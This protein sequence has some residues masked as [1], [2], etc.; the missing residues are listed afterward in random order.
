MGA[1]L[2]ELIDLLDLEKIEE[3]IFR[4]RQ[5][6]E[7]R[8]RVFGGQVAGQALVA[9]T[10]T[11]EPERQVHSLHA[12]FLRPGDPSIPILY[13][14]D[15]IRDGRSFTTRRVVG[16]QHGKA[17][18]NLAAS[19]HTV[20]DG[21]DFSVDGP[22]APDPE[23]LPTFKERMAPYADQMGDW[24]HRPRPIDMRYVDAPLPGAEK[25]AV[26]QTSQRV[27]MRADG[28]LPDDDPTL[29]ACIVTYA[30]DM[31]LLDTTLLPHHVRWTENTIQMASLDHAMW[32][33]RPF[34]ADEWLL[35]VQDTPSTSSSRGL[36]R[37]LI[38]DR[39]GDVVV[40]VMQEGLIRLVR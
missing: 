8:Q 38:Y 33:H 19:F 25:P 6:D 30:S 4:G 39:A 36:A 24:Y 17:I 34:R 14:V 15:R 26:P 29:H 10:R 22:D 23:S 32:F 9:A 7:D 37:G 5:P 13:D 12:Y 18:F 20:E 31:T 1:P 11:V 27:W 16:I 3:N 2:D 40:S 28:T 21:L 35:Y